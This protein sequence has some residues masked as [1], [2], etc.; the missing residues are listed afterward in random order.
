MFVR[1]VAVT[2]ISFCLASYACQ[3]TA[4]P[5]SATTTTDKLASAEQE[6]IRRLDALHGMPGPRPG[7]AS[8][9]FLPLLGETRQWLA[10]APAQEALLLRLP[11]LTT[12]QLV[13]L[14]DV[15]WITPGQADGTTSAPRDMNALAPNYAR[16]FNAAALTALD[17]EKDSDRR[18]L[19]INMLKPQAHTFTEQQATAF[20]K[21]GGWKE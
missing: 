4:A 19:Y 16:R 15:L 6:L 3:A 20:L 10:D 9:G 11:K 12:R 8:K 14:W 2:T 1:S 17:T 7:I 13:T 5:T 18:R 21:A